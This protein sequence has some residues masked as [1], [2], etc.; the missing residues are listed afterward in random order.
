MRE[1][2]TAIFIWED[3]IFTIK[4][5]NYLRVFPGYH[6]FPGGKVDK[7]D[8][9]LIAALS[10]EM[11]EELDFC[12]EENKH[13]I[14]EMYEVGMAIT[15]SFN[16]YRFK[17]YYYAVVLKDEPNFVVDEGEAASHSWQTPQELLFL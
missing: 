6:A 14:K 10:R 7:E 4:R 8:S 9:G 17:T 13:L 5:A 1:A 15:P 2:V 11:K 12:L 3:K 16:P